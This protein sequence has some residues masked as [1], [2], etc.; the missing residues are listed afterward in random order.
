MIL[1][2]PDTFTLQITMNSDWHI[3]AGSG[4][5]EIDS[6]VQ[7]DADGL[8]YI[9][10]KT[11]NG[12]LRDGC[13]QVALALGGDWQ[14][15]IDFLFG[16]QPN[17]AKKET[18]KE[19]AETEPRP[20][21][22]AIHSA[23]LDQTLRDALKGKRELQ[24]AITFIKPSVAI[25]PKK[26][27]AAPQALRFE[28]VARMDAV[29]T[30]EN[31]TLNFDNYSS[32]TGDQKKI[33]FAL[34]IAGTKMIERLGGKRRRGNGNCKITVN[35]QAHDWLKWLKNN[36]QKTSD[37]PQW[38]KPK[39]ASQNK[40]DGVHKSD[41]TWF[42]VPLTITTQSPIVLPKRTVGNVVECLDY[43]PGRYFLGHLHK[44][45]GSFMD[46]S[47]AISRG[48]LVITNATIK[49]DEVAGRPTPFCIFS[50]KLEGG[51]SKTKVVKVGEVYNRFQEAEPKDEQGKDIQIKGERSGYVGQ[52]DSFYLPS[53]KTVKLEVNTHNT[54]HDESQRPSSETDGAVYSYQ[55]IPADTTFKAEL[56]LPQSIK[57]YLSSKDKSKDWWKLLHGEIRIGQSK[58]DQY[59]LVKVSAKKPKQFNSSHQLQNFL[60]VWFLSDVLMRDKRLNPTTDPEI[61]RERLETALDVKLHERPHEKHEDL[62]SLMMKPRRTE[63]WQVRWGLPRPSLLGWQAGSC[64]VYE[65]EGEI[66][67]KKLAEL[68]ARGIG[69]RRAEGYGQICFNDPLLMAELKDKT[70]SESPKKL[71]DKPDVDFKPIPY[72]VTISYDEQPALPKYA[73]T[74]E[75]AAWRE[76]IENKA[77]AL[78]ANISDRERI[79]GIKIDGKDS[80]PPMSQL[81]GL[82]SAMR[83]LTQQISPNTVTQWIDAIKQVENRKDKWPQGSLE[84]I[85]SLVKDFDLVWRELEDY[86]DLTITENGKARLES[87]LWAEA[88]RTLVDAMIR[89]HKRDLEKVQKDSNNG[90]A[91]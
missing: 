1:T 45:L 87:D 88:V 21:A 41:S 23:H 30:A 15:W 34:L 27:S 25:D 40:S 73:R 31:C 61:F 75:I 86:N 26:G 37:P 47:G 13:E 64:V 91:T 44:V 24:N 56:R 49:I 12:I 33:A 59:G 66:D 46:V 19:A 5:G 6:E 85:R 29:L 22:L 16:D 20:A 78:A 3:G 65:V 48:E 7:R 80:Q 10:A 17:R 77:L 70:R 52:F 51:L 60:Y 62:L 55:N 54:I 89:A 11:L 9:P 42:T 63:S 69:D 81:G 72:D 53:Y 38:E 68:E 36:H 90:E 39:L 67:S 83:H 28:E 8:P 76:A 35:N 32:I 18:E 79:L 71:E 2:V 58:K 82:R 57:E 14:Q 84:T 43:I 74:I 50:K 4:R